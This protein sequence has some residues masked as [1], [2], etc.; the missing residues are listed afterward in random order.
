M[1]IHDVG[2]LDTPD[3]IY[4]KMQESLLEVKPTIYNDTHFEGFKREVNFFENLYYFGDFASIELVSE[5]E[6]ERVADDEICYT[7]VGLYIR[8]REM[9]SFNLLL[10]TNMYQ[11]DKIV[12]KM[13]I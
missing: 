2:K 7:I 10:L 11:I 13:H 12:G 4:S 8:Q 1:V 5:D 9:G 3:I 6:E